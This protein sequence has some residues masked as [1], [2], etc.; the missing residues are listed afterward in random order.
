MCEEIPHTVKE[1]PD[2]DDRYGDVHVFPSGENHDLSGDCWCHPRCTYTDVM[3][4]VKVWL[5]WP[6]G[7]N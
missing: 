5:H 6:A 1:E 3:N 7:S 2:T 4:N